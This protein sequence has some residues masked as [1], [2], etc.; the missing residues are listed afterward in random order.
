M[1][2]NDISISDL[3]SKD[4][5]KTKKGKV[6]A[7]S[8]GL[9]GVT[10]GIGISL[11]QIFSTNAYLERLDGNFADKCYSAVEKHDLSSPSAQKRT[12]DIY[13]VMEGFG[14]R[15]QDTVHKLGDH[16]F[17]YGLEGIEKQTEHWPTRDV[18]F[19]GDEYPD[20]MAALLYFRETNDAHWAE[21]VQDPKRVNQYTPESGL[22]F[23]RFLRANKDIEEVRNLARG[24][25][26]SLGMSQ[27]LDN[28][29]WQAYLLEKPHF[30]SL[31]KTYLENL[32]EAGEAQ[33]MRAA[34][35]HYIQD[36]ALVD[37]GDQEFLTSYLEHVSILERSTV[38][39]VYEGFMGE[40]AFV[41]VDRDGRKDDAI[42][43][44][45]N[46]RAKEYVIDGKEK[47]GWRL[48]RKTELTMEVCTDSEGGVSMCPS[49]E[50]VSERV[51]YN[52]FPAEDTATIHLHPKTLVDMAAI[53][54]TE[55]LNWTDSEAIL[56]EMYGNYL[57]YA[58][59]LSAEAEDLFKNIHAEIE[60]NIPE[61]DQGIKREGVGLRLRH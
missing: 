2:L 7:L 6:V 61:H 36:S 16:R 59:P 55:Y 40:W 39:P 38:E 3:T 47:F 57:L 37:L 9:V 58:Q 22:I 49:I 14:E 1:Q 46:N 30:E 53:T 12:E 31:V 8:A 32:S 27:R 41:D 17:C 42:K 18:Y 19:V 25:R 28:V 43:L 33:A 10:T 54:G 5:Y 48:S 34:L 50:D 51:R 29:V 11:M 52:V 4:F 23:S 56:T 44:G 24:L 20:E 35:R 45:F 60:A 15:G 26:D 21:L 13:Y